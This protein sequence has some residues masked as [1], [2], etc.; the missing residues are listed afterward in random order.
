MTPMD[1]VSK[2]K[3]SEIM[4]AIRGRDTGPE[5][6]ARRML[7]GNHFRYQPKGI[8]G[9]PDFAHRGKMVVIFID[10]CFWHGCPL[11]YREPKSNTG[12]WRAKIG[13]NM[14]RDRE[15]TERLEAAGWIVVRIWEHE[16]AA[17]A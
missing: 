12:F 1:R 13:R 3:R 17:T 5:L 7:A 6:T 10:G 16:L 2:K 11:H 9:N 14:E 8:P 4:S 15:S